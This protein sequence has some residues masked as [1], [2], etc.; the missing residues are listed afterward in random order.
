MSLI[1]PRIR[2]PEISLFGGD[3][4]EAFISVCN[5]ILRVFCAAA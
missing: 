2:S 5:S 4:N 1:L 3:S